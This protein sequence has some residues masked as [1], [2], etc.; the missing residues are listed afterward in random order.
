M[1][2]SC[3]SIVVLVEILVTWTLYQELTRQSPG[4]C[5]VIGG[6]VNHYQ[7]SKEYLGIIKLSGVSKREHH[8]HTVATHI[9]LGSPKLLYHK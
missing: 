1:R 7:H 3:F 9:Q 6:T 8:D 4:Y 5:K 2:I